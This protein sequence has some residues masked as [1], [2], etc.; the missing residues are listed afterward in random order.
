MG[1]DLD[2]LDD[3]FADEAV[4]NARAVGK[5]Q[6]KS[7][8]RPPRKDA[9]ATSLSSSQA[10][11]TIDPAQSESSDPRRR[12]ESSEKVISGLDVVSNYDGGW[13]ASIEKSVTENADI[14][15]GLEAL[16][17]FLP[18][19]TTD[20]GGGPAPVISSVGDSTHR[21]KVADVPKCHELSAAVDPVTAG[22][23]I[24]S[25]S[26]G[27][28]RMH[29]KEL[30]R[31][32]MDIMDSINASEFT[33]NS[34]HRTGKFQPKPKL[35]MHEVKPAESLS[36]SLGSQSVPP[37]IS[38]AEKDFSPTFQQDDVLD[39]SS[40]GFTHTLPTE[41]SSEL[42]LNEESMNLTE[43]TQ[44]D[45][46]IPLECP[47]EIPAKLASRRAKIGRNKTQTALDPS[48]QQQKTSTS[49]QE[50]EMGRS[51]RP[52]KSKTNFCELGDEVEDVV[53]A[54][55]EF[56]EECPVNSAAEEETV[57]N[58]EFQVESDS[59]MKK[60][61]QKFEKPVRKR[62]ET[63]ASDKDAKPKK[64]SHSTRRRRVD[65]VLLATPEDEI[66][67][68]KVPLRDLILLAE[69]KEREMKKEEAGAGV[70]ANKQSNGNSSSRYNQE[71]TFT[72]EQNG[73]YNDGQG[74]PRIE[75]SPI[76]FNYHTHMDRT[77]SIR[78][79][80]QD[81]E[82]FYE[83]VRQFGTDLSMIQQLFPDRTRRQVK[84]KYKKEERQHPLRLREALTNRTKDHSHFEKVIERLKQIAAEENQ[85]ADNDESIDLT[86]NEVDE[87]TL[88]AGDEE[89]K[90]EHIDEEVNENVEN[91]FTEV[92]SPS[93]SEDI[94]DDL[95]IWSQY[96][97]G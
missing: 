90:D 24:V 65:K 91:D 34:G 49:C 60:V 10:A 44:L 71:E 58:E 92:Q 19:T 17:D 38:Y 35:Q 68:Q 67:Y 63:E 56:S 74:S 78:W 50:N 23:P 4:K 54:S 15:I 81:T 13:H 97:S 18:H 75:E 12:A 8:F 2:P 9:A 6:P 28:G 72:S 37:E 84:L 87:G 77:P 96:K 27:C 70:T 25:S 32:E 82:L 26:D 79:S 43:M 33:T 95:F 39:L 20:M 48:Q 42:P 76:Y 46:G 3:I 73:E 62:K 36:C 85:N 57:N 83:A 52:R 53:R 47:P 69:H 22:K 51:L 40:L 80:K 66:E 29:D 1:I 94:E 14:F 88:N 61:K 45:S 55:E 11:Q 31:E 30:G 41:A 59:Q 5:F 16:G 93:K 7:K 89:A 21:C 64:F 86:G